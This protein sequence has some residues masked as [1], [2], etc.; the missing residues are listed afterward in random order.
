[1][2]RSKWST[3]RGSCSAI[4]AWSEVKTRSRVGPGRSFS[5]FFWLLFS[6]SPRDRADATQGNYSP[7]A[8]REWAAVALYEFY[9]SAQRL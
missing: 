4:S 7:L 1:M 8:P 5:S 3:R 2:T 9:I 6:G